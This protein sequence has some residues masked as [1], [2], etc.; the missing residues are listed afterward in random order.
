MRAA[1]SRRAVAVVAGLLAPALAQES[2]E[3]R[4][5]PSGVFDFTKLD[6]EAR[7]LANQAAI[8]TI[9]PWDCVR[10]NVTGL[11]WEVKTIDGA[12][13]DQNHTY[14]WYEPDPQR[15]GGDPGFPDGGDCTGGVNCDTHSYVRAVNK[16]GLCGASDWR[17]PTR[18][19]LHTIIDYRAEFPAID[20]DYFPN[21]VARSFWSAE[22]NTT[23]PGY[24]WYTDF[25][26]GLA[27]YYYDKSAA[28]AVRLVRGGR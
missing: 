16:R 12:L 4:L 9:T 26:F 14:S 22:P 23:Y 13:R 28:K 15:N 3:S 5:L 7:A 20:L 18:A 24:A 2:I 27:S 10:D 21:T 6:G 8:Y 17:L 1:G 19:E 11:T 25:K